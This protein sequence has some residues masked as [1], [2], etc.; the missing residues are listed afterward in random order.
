MGPEACVHKA[1]GTLSASLAP[2]CP[3]S[4]APDP[5]ALPAGV[6][7]E[8]VSDGSDPSRGEATD[9]P[10]PPSREPVQVLEGVSKPGG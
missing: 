5:P 8:V 4:P 7:P 3:S 10:L 6:F 9:F 2:S 1:S